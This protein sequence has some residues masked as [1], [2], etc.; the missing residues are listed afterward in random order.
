[1]IQ[2]INHRE[3]EALHDNLYFYTT[4]FVFR[5]RVLDSREE[6]LKE[7]GGCRKQMEAVTIQRLLKFTGY[8]TYVRGGIH[9]GTFTAR[10]VT[11]EEG[12][13]I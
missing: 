2:T 9:L 10:K 13:K 12:S 4:F 6:T 1:M 8:G 7:K 3:F 5:N 11:G